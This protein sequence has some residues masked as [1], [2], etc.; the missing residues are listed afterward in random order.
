MAAFDAVGVVNCDVRTDEGLTGGGENGRH[1]FG[2]IGHAPWGGRGGALRMARAA[3]M[4]KRL[5]ARAK[6]ADDEDDT[7]EP[8]VFP[9]DLIPLLAPHKKHGKL[10]LRVERLPQQTRLSAGTRNS[11]GSWSLTRD[12]LEDLEYIVPEGVDATTS[13]SVRVVSLTAGSTLAVLDYPIVADGAPAVDGRHDVAGEETQV[14]RLLDELAKVKASL[15]ERDRTLAVTPSVEASLV[16]AETRWAAEMDARLAAETAKAALQLEQTRRAWDAEQSERL[17][18]LEARAQEMVADARERAL[19]DAREAALAAERAWKAEEAARLATAEASWRE[20]LAKTSAEADARVASAAA[21]DRHSDAELRAVRE[22]VTALQA[23]L[24]ARDAA[25]AAASD[26]A[27]RAKRDAEDA[28]ARAQSEWKAAEAARL[29]AAEA[30]WRASSTAALAGASGD[31]EAGLLAEVTTLRAAVAERDAALTRAEEAAAALRSE[32][33]GLK[34]A[35]AERDAALKRAKRDADE[36]LAK[37]QSEWKTAEAARLAA[38]EAQWRA[39]STAALAGASVDREAGL[40]AEVTTLRAAVAE[41][42]AALTR[43]EE[44]AQDALAK[45]SEAGEKDAALR[46]ELA[47]LKAAVAERDAALKRAEDAAARAAAADEHA[48]E[49]M[50]AALESDKDAEL[51]RLREKAATLEAKLI[52]A[53]KAAEDEQLKW[54]RDAQDAIARATKDWIA[55]EGSRRATTEAQVRKEIGAQ[56]AQAT[57]RYEAAEAALAQIRLRE[58]KMDGGRSEVELAGARSAL[59][60]REAELTRL[61]EEIEALRNGAPALVEA[62]VAAAPANRYVR[63][64]SIAAAIGVAVVV[65][66]PFVSSLMTPAPVAPVVAKVVEA[67][68]PA[69]APVVR[70]AVLSL[71]ARLRAGPST[72]VGIVAPLDKGVAVTIVEERGEWIRVRAAAAEGKP[73]REGWVKVSQIK[74]TTPVTPPSASGP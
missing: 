13:L 40:L 6:S 56:L 72:K 21:A 27:V 46:S 74:E 44:A 34:A 35:V 38:A 45:V 51:R 30:Q 73:L 57:S 32:L 59:V 69:P 68:A 14:E 60:A 7:G 48:R 52:K 18:K 50:P 9:I 11:D 8:R 23:T 64:V 24:G 61:R 5:V 2:V 28:L 47:G 19:S 15:A 67:P 41:R 63:D 25:I 10:T 3:Q 65:L 70:T 37:A 62:P 54:Q 58:A 29:A 16:A 53:N 20:Q 4:G 49:V 66:Y 43:A 55:K 26:A 36:A 22:Q 1:E 31:R 71:D 39:S 12:E 17:A 42:D 33:A